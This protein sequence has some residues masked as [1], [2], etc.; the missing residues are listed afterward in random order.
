MVEKYAID[1]IMPVFEFGIEK[2]IENKDLLNQKDKHCILPSLPH[3]KK[4]QDKGLLYLYLKANGF[5]CPESIITKP[6]ELP[7]LKT[8]KFPLIA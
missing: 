1:V 5:P 3:F 6:N 8:L 7:N 4:A 2:L